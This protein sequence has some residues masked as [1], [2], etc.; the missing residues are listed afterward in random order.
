MLLMYIHVYMY[1]E[2]QTNFDGEVGMPPDGVTCAE[3]QGMVNATQH[4]PR[5]W[6]G[7]DHTIYSAVG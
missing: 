2:L 5:E 4:G 1:M 6:I 3:A 7:C